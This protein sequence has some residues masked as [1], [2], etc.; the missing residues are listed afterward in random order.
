MP[1]ARSNLR[2][3]ARPKII[4]KKTNKFVRFEAD[5]WKRM[6]VSLSACRSFL[7]LGFRFRPFAYAMYVSVLLTGRERAPRC[8]SKFSPPFV[9][10]L[11]VQYE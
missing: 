10:F 5:M 11:C 1:G 7:Q 2:P 6:A 8:C 3:A 4:K 9:S